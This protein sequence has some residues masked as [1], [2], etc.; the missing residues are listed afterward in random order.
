M[1]NNLSEQELRQSLV[2]CF[3]LALKGLHGTF[4]RLHKPLSQPV[5]GGKGQIECA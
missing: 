3:P 2:E 1:L 4:E 5:R